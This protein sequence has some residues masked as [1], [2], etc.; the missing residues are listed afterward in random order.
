MGLARP[1]FW[2]A[3]NFSATLQVRYVR[4]GR[5]RQGVIFSSLPHPEGFRGFFPR[6]ARSLPCHVASIA[7]GYVSQVGRLAR[8][9]P[10]AA[11]APAEATPTVTAA[12]RQPGNS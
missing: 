3:G 12:P 1:A 10:V 6:L 8:W 5:R 9:I 7:G 11:F 2:R 4:A